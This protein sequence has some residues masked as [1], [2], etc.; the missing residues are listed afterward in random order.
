MHLTQ[1]RTYIKHK[2]KHTLNINQNIIQKIHYHVS[3][4]TLNIN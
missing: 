3:K 1:I 4:H 2:S